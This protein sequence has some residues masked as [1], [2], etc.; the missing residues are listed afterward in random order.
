[1]LGPVAK[2]LGKKRLIIVADGALQYL[3]FCALPQPGQTHGLPLLAQHEIVNLPSASIVAEIRSRQH[4]SSSSE[5]TIAILADPVFDPKDER[6]RN[7][8]FGATIDSLS[9]ERNDLTRSAADLGL[10]R[11]GEVYLSRLLYTRKEADAVASVF[12]RQNT[13]LALDFDANRS[14][15][16]SG[17][18]GGY[19]IIHFATHGFLNSR[20]PELSG[21]VLSLVNDKGKPQEGFL[22]LQDIY[23]LKLDS[24]LV[25]LSGCETA[26]G[27]QIDGEG[28]VGLT[29]GFIYAG[30]NRV[31]ASLWRVS[32]LGTA[33]L[34]ADFYKYLRAGMR[35]PS[36]LRA[37]QLQLWRHT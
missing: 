2:L 24:D 20:R 33:D 21:L 35:P 34:M 32:D 9:A 18:L 4:P 8:L 22:N 28:L 30:A 19:R 31:I 23:D 29:R 36:A 15:V 10:A 7:R 12:P 27:K 5:G 25:V 16:L 13:L 37:A 26:L 6:V 17:A 11:N 14:T 3:P 1:V